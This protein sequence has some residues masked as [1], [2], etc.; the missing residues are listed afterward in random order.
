M[1]SFQ[2]AIMLK[3]VQSLYNGVT[4]V[5]LDNIAEEI[6]ATMSKEHPDYIILAARIAISNLHKQTKEKFS[7][8]VHLPTT[9]DHLTLTSSCRSHSRPVHHD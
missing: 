4:T 2:H 7:G 6:A 9:A 3:V 1:R 8:N 5:K